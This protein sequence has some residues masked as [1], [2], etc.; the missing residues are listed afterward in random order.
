MATD[1]L[2]EDDEWRILAALEM[3][4]EKDLLIEKSAEL[5]TY[6]VMQEMAAKFMALENSMEKGL[7]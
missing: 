3:P 2:L 7:E 5:R 1:I 4:E 6:F